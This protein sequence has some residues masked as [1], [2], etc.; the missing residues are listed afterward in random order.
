MTEERGASIKLLFQLKKA[1]D[2]FF[3]DKKVTVTGLRPEKLDE[4]VK[5]TADLSVKLP[6]IYKQYGIDGPTI[7]P[8]KIFKNIEDKLLKYELAHVKLTEKA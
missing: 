7:A 1:L 8:M 4:T 2:Q 3:D 6:S 5:H